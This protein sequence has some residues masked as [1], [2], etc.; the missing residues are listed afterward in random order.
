MDRPEASRFYERYGKPLETE[1]WGKFLAVHPDGRTILADGCETLKE[2]ANAELGQGVYVF[3]MGLPD[4]RQMT[5]VCLLSEMMT[6]ICLHS[7]MEPQA[8]RRG[9]AHWFGE[10]TMPNFRFPFL[11]FIRSCRS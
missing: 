9:Q 8:V 2:R 3:K 1:H 5:G 4:A 11:P 10:L 6:D 7:E